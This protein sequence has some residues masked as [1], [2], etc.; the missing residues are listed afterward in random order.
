M[1]AQIAN[2]SELADSWDEE[3]RRLE[4]WWPRLRGHDLARTEPQLRGLAERVYRRTLIN[5]ADDPACRH[6]EAEP[7]DLPFEQIPT[8]L[9]LRVISFDARAAG[10]DLRPVADELA[11]LR[12]QRH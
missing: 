10:V 2:A 9:I 6:V 8:P 12:R 11:V 3:L 7:I 5:P 1:N 4:S